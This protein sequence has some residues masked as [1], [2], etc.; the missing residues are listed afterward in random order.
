[1][2]GK[3]PNTGFIGA[4]TVATTLAPALSSKGY[5]V[6]AVANR[7]RASAESLACLI[8]GCRACRSDQG[9]AD[10]AELVFIT[11]PDDAIA[12]VADHVKWRPGQY[13]VH[14]SGADSVA[15]L[16]TAKQA[17]AMVGVFHPLQ[18]FAGSHKAAKN[19]P[20]TT[21]AIEAEEP[22]L[23]LLA[24]MAVAL[25]GRYIQIDSRHKVVYHTAAVFA[26]NYLVTLVKL[27]ADLW[28]TSG[29]PR[30]KAISALMPL[31]KGTLNNIDAIGIPQCLSGPIAR[32]DS[33]TI[34]KH[35]AALQQVAPE[36]VD[37]YRQLGLQT[38]PIARDKGKIDAERAAEIEA[39]LNQ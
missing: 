4:G 8:K 17:G 14:C 18:T 6:I 29:I 5:P 24:A 9:V 1:M 36:L 2:A 21:F 33:G 11:T 13:V 3:L 20:G 26:C 35:L 19:L 28:Q 10:S 30:E 7:S 16:E 15:S 39:L 38:I 25:G 22:L 23:G 34:K 37:T 12:V 32:G 27:A 31:L